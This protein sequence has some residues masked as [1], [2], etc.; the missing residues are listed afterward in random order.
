MGN[1]DKW[2]IRIC[3]GLEYEINNTKHNK[4]NTWYYRHE[5]CKFLNPHQVAVKLYEALTKW[6]KTSSCLGEYFIYVTVMLAISQLDTIADNIVLH[7]TLCS[8][9]C[10]TVSAQGLRYTSGNR[11]GTTISEEPNLSIYTAYS[12]WYLVGDKYFGI[13]T[14][15]LWL[16]LMLVSKLTALQWMTTPQL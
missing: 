3:Q 1:A 10:N 7:K 8:V 12:I 11:F 13:I 2:I 14:S 5:T 6:T 15:V 4:N 16:S 9:E